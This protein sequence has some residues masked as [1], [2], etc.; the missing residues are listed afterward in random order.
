M[1]P[2]KSLVSVS[3]SSI[4]SSS[5]NIGTHFT[6]EA[7]RK[8]VWVKLK[9][10]SVKSLSDTLTFKAFLAQLDDT[11]FAS[12]HLKQDSERNFWLL[13]H[14]KCYTQDIMVGL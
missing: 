14:F 7:R 5:C 6:T 3:F 11:L 4:L 13:A 2:G 10:G 8:L 9:P 1:K 12:W